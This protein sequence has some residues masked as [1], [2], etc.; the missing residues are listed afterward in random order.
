MK[1]ISFFSSLLFAIAFYFRGY[2]DK[3][4]YFF[5]RSYKKRKHFLFMGVCL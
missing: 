2:T 3:Y 4:S 1:L 5:I